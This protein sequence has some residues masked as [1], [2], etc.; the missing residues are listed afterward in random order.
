MI[1]VDQSGELAADLI[2]KGQ[3][4]VL[5]RTRPELEPL[6]KHMWEQ[7]IHHR[8]TFNALQNEYRVRP[9]LLTDLWKVAALTLGVGTALM[10]KEAA[11]ACTEAVETVIGG[12]YQDQ[13]RMLESCPDT[14]DIKKLRKVVK[15]FRDEELEHLDIAVE[16]DS[17][18][19]RPYWLLTET[20][21]TGCR[22]AIWVA[23]RI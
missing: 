3:Y 18:E 2:Y 11:M 15:Q 10:G 8:K 14:D 5:T 20:I 7:E 9:S 12:H 17:A 23:S 6:L 16:N 1:R 21:K 13:L 19:A 22:A 4:A